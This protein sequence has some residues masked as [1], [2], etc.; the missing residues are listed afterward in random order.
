M[1]SLGWLF[2][3]IFFLGLFRAAFLSDVAAFEVL[4]GGIVDNTKFNRKK[5]VILIDFKSQR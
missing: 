1:S 2:G 5:V 4:V 3:L